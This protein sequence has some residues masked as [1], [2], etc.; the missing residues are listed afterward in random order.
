MGSYLSIPCAVSIRSED[1]L[2]LVLMVQQHSKNK[3]VLNLS[4]DGVLKL[5]KTV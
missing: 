1:Q 4:K 2:E 5:A 3:H